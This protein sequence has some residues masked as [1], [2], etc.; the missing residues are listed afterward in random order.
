MRSS[1]LEENIYALVLF[2]NSA[3][4]CVQKAYQVILMNT[5]FSS[6][7]EVILEKEKNHREFLAI[8]MANTD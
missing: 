3:E 4:C 8:E 1:E 2:P 7:I 6:V 5:D